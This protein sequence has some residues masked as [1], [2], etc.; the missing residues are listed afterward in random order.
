MSVRGLSVSLLSASA[1]PL[2]Q[3]LGWSAL[4]SASAL[5]GDVAVALVSASAQLVV[6]VVLVV[7]VLAPD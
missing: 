2:A 1:E 4:A 7:E 3:V 6:V 5:V